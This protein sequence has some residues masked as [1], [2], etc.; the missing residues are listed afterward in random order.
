MKTQHLALHF[1]I[2]RCYTSRHLLLIRERPNLRSQLEYNMF[3][4]WNRINTKCSFA[5]CLWQCVIQIVVFIHL[6]KHVFK[7]GTRFI[8]IFLKSR[9]K[10]EWMSGLHCWLPE[11]VADTAVRGLMVQFCVYSSGHEHFNLHDS[12]YV[13]WNIVALVLIYSDYLD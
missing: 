1:L 12:C 11:I 10:W 9:S 6:Y 4:C 8:C 7:S 2:K 13:I 5:F 3:M